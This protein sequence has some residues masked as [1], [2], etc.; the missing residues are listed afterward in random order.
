MSCLPNVEMLC[1]K[2]FDTYP[3]EVVTFN[4]DI[5][6]ASVLQEL[7]NAQTGQQVKTW[8]NLSGGL[9]ITTAATGVV[10]IPR[11][12]V[13]MPPGRYIGDMSITYPDGTK[14][15]YYT[16]ELNVSE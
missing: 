2:Q 8:N 3:E 4:L 7:R 16:I 6:G 15:T 13:L 14:E 11:W 9:V 12:Q 1:M 5:T 10:T